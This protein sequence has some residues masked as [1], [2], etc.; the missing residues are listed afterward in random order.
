[1][2]QKPTALSLQKRSKIQ[3][4]NNKPCAMFFFLEKKYVESDGKESI[5]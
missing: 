4:H 5:L 1:M 3:Q 2:N